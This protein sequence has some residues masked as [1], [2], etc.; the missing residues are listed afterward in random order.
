MV[1]RR[2]PVPIYYQIERR[3]EEL[4]QDGTLNPG[5][6]LPHTAV[7]SRA[8]GVNHLTVRRALSDLVDKKII[9]RTRRAGTFIREDVVR[10]SS[11]CVGFFYFA[12]DEAGMM[13]RARYMQLFL[14]KQ[15]HD[16]KFFGFDADFYRDT[17]LVRE[18]GRRQLRG[19]LVVPLSG[20]ESKRR[21]AEL[22]QAGFPYVRF[23][24]S[25][26]QGELRAPL[27]RG[28]D[29]QKTRACLDYLWSKGHRN[30]GLVLAFNEDENEAEYRRFFA[31]KGLGYEERWLISLEFAGP[32]EQW[33]KM[34][35]GHI[36][37]G[38]LEKNRDLTAIVVA[39]SP[40][41]IDLTREIAAMGGRIPDDFS[42][43]CL[44]DW[45]GLRV[46]EP[47]VTAMRLS[48]KMLAEQACRELR[49]V[50]RRGY[51]EQERIIQVDYQ[52]V[53]RQSVAPAGEREMVSAST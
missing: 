6:Q 36:A 10:H 26:F 25:S 22:E 49:E 43:F 3:I 20:A 27:I 50:M 28:N 31:D 11:S 34:P 53:E 19:A 48:S 5:E 30:I 24:N 52:L 39:Y 21:L 40:M 44:Y 33:R 12:E 14:A 9:K 51:G 7:L 16:L 32:F 45:E 8:L 47:E 37:R 29:R 46:L 17:D 4:L 42:L 23:G 18:M 41:C 38:Y 15:G 2:S 1:D 35:G 13:D